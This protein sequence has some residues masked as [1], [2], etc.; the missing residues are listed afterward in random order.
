MVNRAQ[1]SKMGYIPTNDFVRDGIR[2]E[3][4][5]K[6]RYGISGLSKV[7]SLVGIIYRFKR[8]FTKVAEH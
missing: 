4:N 8:S 1:P 3:L 2:M 7:S 5:H 6:Q